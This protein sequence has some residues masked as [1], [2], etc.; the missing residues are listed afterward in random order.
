MKT[1]NLLAFDFG[2]SS[3]RAILGRFDGNRIAVTTVHQFPNGPVETTGHLYWDILRFLLELKEGLGKASIETA[4]SLS[5]VGIDTWGVD[6]G[7]L[8]SSGQLLGFPYHYRDA[9]TSGMYDAAFDRLSKQEIFRLTG[10][11]FNPFNTLFQ[12]LSMK[13]HQPALLEQAATLLLMPDLLSYLLTGVK[14]TEYT[15][16]STSQL[17]DGRSRKWNAE[18][19][20]AMGFP[21]RLFTDIQQP[22][23]IRGT[24]LPDMSEEVRLQKLPVIAVASHDTASA[25]VAVPAEGDT[26]AYLSSGTWSLLGVE[27]KTPVMDPRA[28]KWN[29][30][31]E[32][33]AGGVYRLLRNVMGLWILQECKRTWD[34]E[35]SNLDFSDMVELAQ[36]SPPF[37]ALIDPDDSSF[38]SPGD[39]PARIRD[40]CRMTSQT[41]PANPSAIVRIVLESLALKYR[42]VVDRLEELVGRKIESLYLVGGGVK[43]T[44]LNQ[45]TADA[46]QRPVFGGP[47]EATALG[48]LLVQ[49]L[50]LGELGSIAEIRQI[51]RVSFPTTT[52]EPRAN[53]AWGEA[54]DR[55]CRLL[56]TQHMHNT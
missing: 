2:A 4:R 52:F 24:L 19:M 38:Y 53:E 25:V 21:E 41:L 11:A 56:N 26:H 34:A 43:N 51:V 48:N 50:A 7:L 16:A 1:L 23:T 40:Y 27:A 5:G 37:S 49:A 17:L 22:G 30:T 35:G 8:D 12:L 36:N 10:I 54:Y 3:G 18:I 33:G 20:K 39:M 55:F 45:F 28:L 15:D 47:P 46:L 42:W 32:G 31:N 6:Y 13:V 29:F 44:L 14:M 9:R